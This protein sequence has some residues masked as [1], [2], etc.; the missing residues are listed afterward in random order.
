MIKYITC[1]QQRSKISSPSLILLT[2]WKRHNREKQVR[3][4]Q[5]QN[6]GACISNTLLCSQ[7]YTW[8]NWAE[9]SWRENGGANTQKCPPCTRLNRP[10]LT[11]S[12]KLLVRSKRG[13]PLRHFTCPTP[14]FKTV[15]CL[16]KTVM[17]FPIIF[18]RA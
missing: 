6:R 5:I 18:S 11:L 8:D 2:N 15:H 13:A 10:Y 7:N 12:R 1:F 16:Y 14:L 9:C 3:S 17:G 4:A